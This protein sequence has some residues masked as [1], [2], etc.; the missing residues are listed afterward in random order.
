MQCN[1]LLWIS[2]QFAFGKQKRLFIEPFVNLN[3]PVEIDLLY[4]QSVTDVFEQ[5]IPLTKSDAVIVNLFT[6]SWVEYQLRAN[7]LENMS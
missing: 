7:L 6:I 1:Q 5:K 4:H 3:D 2:I